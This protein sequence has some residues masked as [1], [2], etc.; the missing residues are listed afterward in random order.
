[1]GSTPK[2]SLRAGYSISQMFGRRSLYWAA[3][4]IIIALGLNYWVLSTRWQAED[5]LRASLELTENAGQLLSAIQAAETGQRGF[6]ITQNPSYLQPYESALDDINRLLSELKAQVRDDKKLDIDITRLEMLIDEK[7]RG[8]E[9]TIALGKAQDLS[10]A[11][12]VVIANLDKNITSEIRAIVQRLIDNEN[13]LA[14]RLNEGDRLAVFYQISIILLGLLIFFIFSLVVQN[15]RRLQESHRFLDL[16]FSS[17][18]DLLFVKDDQFRIVQANEAFLNLYPED[19]RES[20]FGT[21]TVE[22]YNEDEAEKF[23]EQDRIAFKYGISEIEETLTF[24][25]GIDRTLL[26]KKILFEDDKGKKFILGIGRDISTLKAAEKEIMRSNA[27]LERFAYVASHDLQEPLRMITGFT[28]LLKKDY[29]EKLDDK[30]QKYIEMAYSGAV[31]MKALIEDLLE[32]SRLSNQEGR[33]EAVLVTDVMKTV[34]ENL[35]ELI[36]DSQA[37][38][39]YRTL[40]V[41]MTNP[42]RL[43]RVLQNI[44]GNSIK[45]KKTSQA[46]VID[47]SVEYDQGFWLFSLR[48]NGMGMKQEYCDQIFEP[49][50]RLHNKGAYPGTGIGLAVCRRIID[51][52]G[53]KIWATSEEGEGATFYFTIPER[54]KS[55]RR[56]EK[57]S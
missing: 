45:Y 21:T 51:D 3:A 32:Y 11:R 10:A 54:R 6:L 22:Q 1:M 26:T 9:Q 19:M 29:G 2:K 48:D 7:L 38:I 56:K 35:A 52:A 43:L 34:E 30:G 53:G 47:V 44:I 31:R 5:Q 28:S 46:P 27:E 39:N 8:L 15:G 13:L 25:D 40:P 55:D 12:E 50:K 4:L 23:L 16:V 24:P 18:P 33:Y 49:F 41:I 20:I 57:A 17:I 42:I 36:Q 14:F 37:K